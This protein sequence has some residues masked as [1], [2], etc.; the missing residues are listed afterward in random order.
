MI[1]HINSGIE[2]RHIKIRG[3]SLYVKNKLHGSVQDSTFKTVPTLLTPHLLIQW[4]QVKNTLQ[5]IQ[6]HLIT[7]LNQHRHDYIRTTIF[8]YLIVEVLLT[9]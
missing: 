1:P 7:I 6:I 8:S 2:R 4:I 3:I 5:L 9:N